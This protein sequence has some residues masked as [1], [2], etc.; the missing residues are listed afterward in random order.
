MF[1]FDN[2]HD[3]PLDPFWDANGNNKYDPMDQWQRENLFGRDD[4]ER[5]PGAEDDEVD[6]FLDDD[7]D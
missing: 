6:S 4:D 7:D 2:D 1:D 3:S 5:E